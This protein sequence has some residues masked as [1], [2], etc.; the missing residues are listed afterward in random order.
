M[1]LSPQ[2]HDGQSN[3]RELDLNFRSFAGNWLLPET[4]IARFLFM[5]KYR[6]MGQFQVVHFLSGLRIGQG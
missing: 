1:F 5:T 2:L 6:K 4:E 3:H